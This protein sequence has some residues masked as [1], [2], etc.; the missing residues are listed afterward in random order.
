MEWQGMNI[1]N[2]NAVIFS[3][4]FVWNLSSP[5]RQLL[6]YCFERQGSVSPSMFYEPRS[7]LQSIEAHMQLA[8][9][10]HWKAHDWFLLHTICNART[11]KGRKLYECHLYVLSVFPLELPERA[12]SKNQ[13]SYEL[14]SDKNLLILEQK[15]DCWQEIYIPVLFFKKNVILW[16]SILS[17]I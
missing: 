1:L 11:F 6:P 10:L 4:P 17:G 12:S 15:K 2:K 3:N 16:N 13:I 14:P 9:C 7:C 8:K 5:A